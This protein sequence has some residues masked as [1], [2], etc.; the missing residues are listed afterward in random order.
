MCYFFKPADFLES[1]PGFVLNVVLPRIFML[2]AYIY[3]YSFSCWQA[4]SIVCLKLSFCLLASFV[5]FSFTWAAQADLSAQVQ[6]M[7]TEAGPSF[8]RTNFFTLTQN[9]TRDTPDGAL[10]YAAQQFTNYVTLFGRRL[11]SVVLGW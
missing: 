8:Y 5:L 1:L 9:I 11:W 10:V 4:R 3:F 6:A 7:S 2:I